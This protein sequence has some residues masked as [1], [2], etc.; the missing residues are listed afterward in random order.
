MV[1]MAEDVE[2]YLFQAHD[3]PFIVKVEDFDGFDV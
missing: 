1:Y 2:E 3:I